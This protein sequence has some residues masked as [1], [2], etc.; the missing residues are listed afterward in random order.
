MMENRS[1]RRSFLKTTVTGAAGILAASG[2]SA[3]S[4]V[5]GANDR[6]RIGLIGCG[7]RGNYLRGVV[8]ELGEEGNAEI[9]AVCDVWKKNLNKTGDEVK[10][11]FGA[12]PKRFQRY[13]DLLALNDVDAVMI[14]TPDFA[15]SRILTEAAY[16][17]KHVFCEKPMSNNLSDACA[18]VDAVES[19]GVICQVGTQRRSSPWFQK[20]YELVRSGVLG[21]ITEVEC[22]WNRNVPSWL[23]DPQTYADMKKED[24]DWEQ[25]LM[26]LP[27]RPF[28][29][30]RLS[31]WHLYRDYT[32]GLVGLL[33]SHIIDVG[34]W[35]MDD[36]VPES[37]VGLGGILIWKEKREHY[38][39]MES[40]FL[41][42]KGF[43]MRFVSRLGNSAGDDNTQFRG[44]RGTFD[45]TTMTASGLG[46][47]KEEAIQEPIA[48]EKP[49]E[50]KDTN[51]VKNWLDSIRS[52][53]KPTADVHAGYAHSVIA[54]MAH[55]AADQ[56]RRVRYDPI[57]R[58]IL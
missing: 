12:D 56:G 44:L 10:A 6:V 29:P 46:G 4:R 5:L 22:S 50:E 1:D 55:N 58:E 57:R 11:N 47:K 14:A 34:T 9:V 2:M 51:H 52:G 27:P 42:P 36:P 7:G 30:C 13:R 15:H 16:A 31:C 32:I 26:Y 3:S 23:D 25:F 37:A 53:A 48:V 35:F 18:A 8:K 43:I 28:D 45:T 33:G 24:V 21:P 54:I 17:K 20:A 38:D 49:P 19:T 41:F 40:A 39:T